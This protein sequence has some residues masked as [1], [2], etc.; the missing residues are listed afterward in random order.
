MID[1]VFAVL[2]PTGR[3]WGYRYSHESAVEECVA[4]DERDGPGHCVQ[5]LVPADE[6]ERLSS[7]VSRLRKYARHADTC[8]SM[9]HGG[10]CICGFDLV[11]E[12]PAPQCQHF[13]AAIRDRID[14]KIY[15]KDCGETI[16]D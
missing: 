11:S 14:G 13:N 12:E 6:I 16:C 2:L 15:C 4:L 8:P 7:E 1:E 5:R 10:K 9:L 3:L